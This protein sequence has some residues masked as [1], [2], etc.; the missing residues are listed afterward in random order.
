MDAPARQPQDLPS[1]EDAVELTQP[2][3]VRPAMDLGMSK[4]LRP[5]HAAVAAMVRN[6]I[7]PLDDEFLAEVPKGDRSTYTERQT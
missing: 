1:V 7:E 6:E 5:I 4:R 2:S 3:E